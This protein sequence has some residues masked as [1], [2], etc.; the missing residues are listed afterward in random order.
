M[1][2]R[3]E[4]QQIWNRSHHKKPASEE[5]EDGIVPFVEN[6]QKQLP[7]KAA[8]LDVGCG[9]GRN[10][11]YLSQLGFSVWGC[12]LSPVSLE[13]AQRRAQQMD[14]PIN[15]Q[16]SD[17][18]CLPYRDNSF[19]GAI[20]VHVLPYHLKADIA[21]GIRELWRVVHPNGWV[22]VDFLDC[23]DAEYGC[24]QTLEEHTFLDPEGTP[25]HFSSQQE[26]SELL[27]GFAS[28]C[29]SRHELKSSSPHCRVIWRI[30][31]IKSRTSIMEFKHRAG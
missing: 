20:C 24:G 13:V 12:D 3:F 21:K 9:R 22:Y 2:D 8:L 26:I 10:T 31:A 4:L 17:L 15:F 19:A 1:L 23:D 7:P 5:P 25:I 27:S 30:W 14:L 29:M 18:T 11:L 6:L 16:V 28:E